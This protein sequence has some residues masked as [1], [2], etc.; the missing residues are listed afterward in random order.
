MK[1][2][3]ETEAV[4]ATSPCCRRV[5]SVA[6][7]GQRACGL[8]RIGIV[9]ESDGRGSRLFSCGSP[10]GPLVSRDEAE[11]KPAGQTKAQFQKSWDAWKAWARCS[12]L[13]LRIIV[14]S[15]VRFNPPG[16]LK[17]CGPRG[18]FIC[19]AARPIPAPSPSAAP[20]P[21]LGRGSY[22]FPAR[23]GPPV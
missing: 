21:H 4:V 12:D 3:P 2:R 19:E 1:T 16:A 14:L 5:R 13:R 22:Q 8:D 18:L 11:S 6:S 17:P 23:A 9:C 20:H 10:E 7:G 15:F